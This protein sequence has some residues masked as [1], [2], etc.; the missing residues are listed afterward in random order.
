MAQSFPRSSFS[1]SLQCPAG[2]GGN[3]SGLGDRPLCDADHLGVYG[4]DLV[5]CLAA[6]PSK[7]GAD[8]SG[9]GPHHL[10]PVP[11]GG[12]RSQSRTLELLDSLGHLGHALGQKTRV[13]RIGDVGGDHRGVGTDLVGLQ[14]LG[15]LGL[16]QQCLVQA[17]DRR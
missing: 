17:V 5:F 9:P 8:G 13:R 2:V 1:Q 6:A 12:L 3:V 4:Q 11:R 15:G 7:V 16:G 14:D 10:S